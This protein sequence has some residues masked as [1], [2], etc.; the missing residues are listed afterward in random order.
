MKNEYIPP[1]VESQA[2]INVTVIATSNL[3][4]TIDSYDIIEWEF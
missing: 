2:I 3:Q 1:R 4:G